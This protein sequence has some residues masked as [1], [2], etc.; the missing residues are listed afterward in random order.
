VSV[1]VSSALAGVLR[2]GRSELNTRFN[3]ARVRRPDLDAEAFA[4]FVRSALD[5]VVIAVDRV[6]PEAVT[7]VARAAYDIALELVG[8][9]LVGRS[10]RTPHV[11]SAWRRILPAVAPLVA[12]EPERAIAAVCNAAHQL[13][14]TAGA[15]PIGW[16]DVMT[17]LGPECRDVATLLTLGQVG[18]WRSGL[19][20][21]RESAIAAADTLP[22]SLAL[23]VVGAS[24]E[25][26]SAIR[27]RL[28]CDPWFDPATPNG[29]RKTPRVVGRAGAFRGFGGL[30][31]EPPSVAM[32]DEQLFVRSGRD[33][34]LMKADAFGATFHRATS[35]DFD[36]ARAA[37]RF[38]DGVSLR[39]TTLSV[40][41][42]S[43]DL[44]GAVGEVSS[45]CANRSTLALTSPHTHA[46][47][48]VALP[49]T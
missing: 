40:R 30:F 39:G 13:S 29:D 45:A 2:S 33:C 22:E 1:T 32:A 9:R 26:W 8:Q 31:V 16:I 11:D 3:E 10:A 6:R 18:A 14:T 36:R 21:F 35:E 23:A 46:I 5:P 7:D 37:S 19:A 25:R 43:T 38:P 15:R 48:L 12:M 17:R 28:A 41:G 42:A 20:H 27:A 44:G 24:G 49:A 34:W 47:V 4:E